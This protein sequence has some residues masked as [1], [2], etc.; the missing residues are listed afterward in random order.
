MCG[1]SGYF[2]INDNY[3]PNII[4]SMIQSLEHRGPDTSGVWNSPKEGLAL[5]HRRLSII[6]L[7][8]AGNQPIIS[9]NNRYVLI[10]NGEIYNHLKIR[11]ELE[12]N[13]NGHSD[14]ETLIEAISEWGIDIALRKCIGMFAFAVWDKKEDTF[15]CQRQIWRKT[16]ILW[17]SKEDF[18]VCFRAKS[19][20]ASP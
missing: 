8:D 16:I 1:I 7:S 2:S 20:K 4:A 18:Y 3:D 15:N 17:C 10:Y 14:S 6:D 9:K 11:S 12:R 13:W 5:A 19:I